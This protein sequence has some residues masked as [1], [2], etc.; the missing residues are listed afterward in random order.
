MKTSLK[1]KATIILFII[2][3][4][5][6]SQ[7]RNINVKTTDY[8]SVNLPSS[9]DYSSRDGFVI[10]EI[11]L[12]EKIIHYKIKSNFYTFKYDDDELIKNSNSEITIKFENQNEVIYFSSYYNYIKISY[13]S[14]MEPL[15][16]PRSYKKVEVYSNYNLGDFFK[17]MN[18][19]IN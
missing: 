18:Y 10:W 15:S 3:W 8:Y 7:G 13:Y 6:Y 11:D 5:S 14:N 17:I 2:T 12:K 16:Y 19:N 9:G 4:L 1:Y